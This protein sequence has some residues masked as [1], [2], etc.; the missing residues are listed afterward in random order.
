MDGKESASYYRHSLQIALLVVV[1]GYCIVTVLAFC[2]IIISQLTRKR[3]NDRHY[4]H[5]KNGE[6][7]LA[8]GGEVDGSSSKH[9]PRSQSGV[10]KSSKAIPITVTIPSLSNSSIVSGGFLES[11]V[12]DLFSSRSKTPINDNN[13]SNS[14][15]SGQPKSPS[16]R[17]LSKSLKL[18]DYRASETPGKTSMA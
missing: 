16:R 3:S 6:S 2:C 8:P 9:P 10:Y 18:S 17:D 4:H 1:V 7:E 15:R 12:P 5:R 14:N 11:L 13:N